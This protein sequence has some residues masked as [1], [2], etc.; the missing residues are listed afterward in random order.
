MSVKASHAANGHAEREGYHRCLTLVMAT[1]QKYI[2]KETS[3]KTTWSSPP[4]AGSGPGNQAPYVGSSILIPM[5][6]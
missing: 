5:E 2:F 1:E 6:Q 3:D 4:I